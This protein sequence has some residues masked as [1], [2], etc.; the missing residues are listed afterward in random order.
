M[1]SIDG[2]RE[3]G[4]GCLS[5]FELIPKTTQLPALVVRQY[6]EQAIGGR[7]FALGLVVVGIVVVSVGISGVDLHKIVNQDHLEYFQTVDGV[8]GML[9]QEHHH[10]S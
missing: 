7:S 3:S 2:P 10:Q 4:V 1:H 5:S 9:C 8:V 6:A